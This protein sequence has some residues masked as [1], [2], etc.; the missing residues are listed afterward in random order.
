[1]NDLSGDWSGKRQFQSLR[2]WTRHY[3]QCNRKG[4]GEIIKKSGEQVSLGT[5]GTA[6]NSP[7]AGQRTM[8][9]NMSEVLSSV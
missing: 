1:M 5:I 2:S 6:K 3:R 8:D 9:R 4:N 7:E